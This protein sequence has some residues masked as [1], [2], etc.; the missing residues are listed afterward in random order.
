ME[1]TG[2]FLQS[3]AIIAGSLVSED[4]AVIGA[5]LLSVAG[6]LPLE[7]ALASIF[8]GIWL[9]DLALYALGAGAGSVV[10]RTDWLQRLVDA[11]RVE[12]GREWFR[13]RGFW[14]LVLCRIIPGT[15]L[16]TYLAA[17]AIRFPFRRFA[18]M[19]AAMALIWI[20]GIFMLAHYVG[21]AAGRW[22]ESFS[23]KIFGGFL[24]C[25]ALVGALLVLR[26][27]A[28]RISSWRRWRQ[29]EFWPAWLFYLPVAAH[30][31]FLSLRYK[32]LTLPSSA[33]PSMFTGGLVGES[34]F[35]TLEELQRKQPHFTATS[36]LLPAAEAGRRLEL[37]QQLGS[38]E[39]F[40]FPLVLKPDKAQRGCG[41]KVVDSMAV[42]QAH[43][44]RI[45]DDLVLQSYIPGPYEAGIFYVRYP[46]EKHGRIFAITEKVFPQLQGDGHHTIEELIYTDE[47]ASL[48]SGIYCTRFQNRLMEV[49]PV[50]SK[51]RLVE[52]GNHAQG[53]IFRDG[54]HLWSEALEARID[55]I[56]R[57]LQGF[58][59]GRYD[60][61]YSSEADLK[62]GQGFKILELNGA[63]AEATSI[64][65][66][67]TSLC[68]AYAVLFEQW[69][70]VFV[71]GAANR[72]LGHQPCSPA[73]LWREWRQSI[74]R[75]AA[76]PPA[77]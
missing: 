4:A 35:D 63:A 38:G 33:N 42:A 65:D 30:Y 71:I 57:S 51:L 37:F 3:L 66:P 17:G 48:L 52:A 47:R 1:A 72:A 75:C 77:D 58:F 22:L 13:R 20:T 29:W 68:Q 56:S 7:L 59:I 14:A 61:R 15:R 28:G 18:W 69:N 73:L 64:Y 46:N 11:K 55:E 21:A 5:A 10:L 8:L 40:S 26:F 41:F 31:I 2:L 36:R 44:Q 24:V 39:P 43:I 45:P 54:F 53:C 60:L 50:G 16:P 34:K 9:G 25:L 27:V 67:S 12:Q 76:L 19:T 6:A 62:Q 23:N 70:L 49:L 74:K 32:S